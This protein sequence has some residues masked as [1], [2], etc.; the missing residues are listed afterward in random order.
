MKKYLKWLWMLLIP[1]AF[2]AD[3][4]VNPPNNPPTPTGHLFG[5]IY[6]KNTGRIRSTVTVGDNNDLNN[7]ILGPNEALLQLDDSQYNTSTNLQTLVS[8][9]TGLILTNDRYAEVDSKGNVIGII[10]ADPQ[11][12]LP[13]IT[14]VPSSQAAVGWTFDGS[15]FI[16]PIVQLSTSTPK[17]H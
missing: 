14:L 15:N 7:I 8:N 2:A 10:L 3:V 16:A 9:K 1:A 4:I 11:D 12:S 6:S 17:T 13:N 5:V